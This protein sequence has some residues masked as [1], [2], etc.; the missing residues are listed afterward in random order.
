MVLLLLVSM[1]AVPISA[2]F[3]IPIPTIAILP[4][5]ITI[6]SSFAITAPPLAITSAPVAITVTAAA[7]TRAAGAISARRRR[8]SVNSPHG[9]WRV[10]GPLKTKR[11]NE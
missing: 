4:L 8:T 6:T 5:T 2:I 11:E 7:A 3:I 10:L 9:R 1:I